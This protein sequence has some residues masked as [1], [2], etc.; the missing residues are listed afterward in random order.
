MLR[1]FQNLRKKDWLLLGIAACLVVA[2]VWLELEI[3]EYM[4]QITQIIQANQDAYSTILLPGSKMVVCALISFAFS[5]AASVFVSAAAANFGTTLR[6]RLFEKVQSFDLEDVAHFSGASLITRTTNDVMQVQMLLVMGLQAGVRAPLMAVWAISR[7]AGKSAEWTLPVAA[8]LGLALLMSCTCF[9][10]SA[11][12]YQKLQKYTDDVNRITR[13]HLTGIPTIRAYGAEEYQRGQF[14]AANQALSGAHLATGRVMAVLTP[15]IQ[16][17]ISLLNLAIYGI[18][19]ILISR[20]SMVEKILLFSEMLVFSQYSIQIIMS[21]MLMIMSF[22]ILPRSSVSARRILEVLEREPSIPEGTLEPESHA[23]G[24]EIEFQNVSLRYPG[25]RENALHHLSF[26]IFPGE[27]VAFVGPTA[28][29]KTSVMNLLPRLYEA[30]EGR[31]LIDGTDIK[32]FQRQ[33]LRNRIGYALQKPSLFSGTIQS[34]IALGSSSRKDCTPALE[35]AQGL[36]FV[37]ALPQGIASPVAHSGDNFSGGEK[38]RLAIARALFRNPK[39]LI[40]DDAM[41]ALDY[42]TE[43]RLRQELSSRYPNATKLIVTQRIATIMDVSKIIVMDHGYLV[44]MGTHQELLEG[45]EAYRTMA[46]LQLGGNG[47]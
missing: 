44:G 43:K 36:D 31:I 11:K 24:S 42:G 22:A 28:S 41:S 45:C 4:A 5:G 38:Q 47:K 1:I 33:T 34:N 16:A 21:F 13:E 46:A 30:T 20:V 19:A 9:V 2:Q 26:R 10:I 35:T 3:P 14:E 17:I 29:G 32:N 15:G 12:Y 25:A 6:K 40:F 18:G 7:I 23:P 39:I 37:Q 27:T 8:A